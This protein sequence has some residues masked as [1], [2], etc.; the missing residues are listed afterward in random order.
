MC[1]CVSI[2][3][4]ITMPSPA[5][6]VLALSG[7][8]RLGPTASILSS[9]TRT[10]APCSTSWASFM[11]RT[12]PPRS[13]IGSLMFA[14]L[15]SLSRNDYQLRP[16][17]RC[18]LAFPRGRDVIELDGFVL[19]RDL[20]GGHVPRQFLIRVA[21]DL[22]RRVGDREPGDIE[23]HAPDRGGGERDLGAGELADLDM[24]RVP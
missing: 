6:M 14:A 24:P 10:S 21:L 18:F 19:D 16:A 13:T 20:F 7:A 22:V 12:V 1:R 15:L 2:M 8:S 17:I 3:P 9:T 5:S 11:V 23:R 4:G